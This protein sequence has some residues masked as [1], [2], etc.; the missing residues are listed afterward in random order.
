[1]QIGEPPYTLALMGKKSSGSR[2][3]A[4]P[5]W[6]ARLLLAAAVLS[7]ALSVPAHAA[8]IQS[9]AQMDH[10]SWIARD[11]APQGI[12]A[13]AQGADG[14]L[15]IGAESGLFNFDGVTFTAFKSPVGDP[16]LPVEPVNSLCVTRDGSLWVGFFQAGAA[17]IK[18]G[19]VQLYS[20]LDDAPLGFLENLV[21]S[22][23][24]SI[25]ALSRQSR[26]LR[27]GPDSDGRWRE[28]PL[29]QPKGRIGRFLID[30]SNTL[31]LAQNGRLYRRPLSQ[32]EYTATD[33]EV[34]LSFGMTEARDGSVWVTD[35]MLAADRGRTQHVDHFGR[36]ISELPDTSY[37]FD[38][39]YA[40]D[41]S[42]I[43]AT[44]D[45]GL[46][47]FSA[48]DSAGVATPDVFG[49]LEGLTSDEVRTL[50]LDADGNI[51]AGGQ[52]GLD[53]FRKS[54]IVRFVP[55][56]PAIRWSLCAGKQGPLW[57]AG[58]N[59]QLY[60]VSGGIP[61]LLPQQNGYYAID[62]S[63]D[64]DAWL[65][66]SSGLWRLHEDRLSQIP[67]VPGTRPYNVQQLV[68]TS[69]HILYAPLGTST[70]GGYW[71]YQDN[72]WNKLGE[73]VPGRGT[74]VTYVD[75][76]D[77]LWMGHSDGYVSLPLEDRWFSSGQAGL[78][79]V[80]TI[81]ETS[82]GML[83]GGTNGLAIVREQSLEMLAF[84]DDDAAAGI[85]A[86]VES[87]NGDVWLN[88][89]RGIVRIAASEIDTAL[90]RLEHR[91]RSDL[92]AEGDFAGARQG[93]GRN[94]SAARDA[95]GKLWFVTV[96]GVVSI[97]PEHWRPQSRPPVISIKSISVDHSPLDEQGI[98]GPRPRVL[99]I[100]YLGVNLTAPDQVIYKYRLDGFDDDWQEVGRRTEAIYTRL[101][102]GNYRFSVM[103]SNGDGLWTAPVA[104][105]AFT[106]QR[107][108]YQT[109]WFAAVCV[110]VALVIGWLAFSMR[111]R[112]ITRE[113]RARAEER[114]EERVRI[115]REL[116]DTLLQGIQGLLLTFHVAAQKISPDNDS[117]TMLERALAT[118]DRMIIE[119]RNRVSRLR[120]EHLS[121]AE[122]VASLENV[123]KDLQF[124]GDVQ[125]RINRSGQGATL[126]A[127]VSDEVFYVAR[128]ALT[129]A[130]RHSEASHI[131]L[132]LIYGKR[133][134]TLICTDDGRG[135]QPDDQQKSGHWGLKGMAERARKLGGKFRCRS[136]PQEGTEIRVS[137]PS[138]KAYP[139]HSRI[140]FYLRALTPP[141]NDPH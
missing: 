72:Q 5:R 64:G 63:P 93:A 22:H 30:S 135:F 27:L 78:G 18:N 141:R 39:L 107:S 85:Q 19:R 106:V 76:Q 127:H 35:A 128:E 15:W 90:S 16:Q 94:A 40:A 48:G 113:V 70:G 36:L 130:F 115:A 116:H 29:P 56:Q 38:I 43:L 98:I 58:T 8:Q 7:F 75:S 73:G 51:W 34:D 122:L 132:D 100:R 55:K 112:S 83:A 44:Q 41:G 25:W 77:R 139:N 20:R 4:G 31:W 84:A 120:S 9:L 61:A 54:Q 67:A 108:F 79:T 96:N 82:H 71:R 111:V 87:R 138:Y 117:R 140:L 81:Q 14:T 103:A 134:F 133:F 62:C 95:D 104:T 97:D 33:V 125:C 6:L 11:G 86:I 105:G 28:E 118:A 91:M 89:A 37:P 47:R 2:L 66:S 53:R 68:A 131:K 32:S 137:I 74:Y 1:M 114:A 59:P 92:L 13:L 12:L 46:H 60:R 124:N 52:R 57:I 109:A 88:A 10:A 136:T 45:K 23:D 69:D 121:D 49:K 80:R 101:P 65:A 26:V 110:G 21:E 42:V 123:S 50:L 3:H 17:H 129:N 102:A 119:G 126:Y 99:E 24:G